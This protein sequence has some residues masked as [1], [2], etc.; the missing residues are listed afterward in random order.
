MTMKVMHL[1]WEFPPYKV[2]GIGSVLDDLTRHQAAQGI[3]TIVVTCGFK[4][5][6]GYEKKDGV[7]IYRFNADYIPAEDF[8]SWALQMGMLMQ[9]KASE[10]INEHKDIDL[11]HAHDWLVATPATSLKHI[12]RIPLVSTIHALECGRYGGIK[13][14][15]QELIH[16]LER[17]LAFESWKII[18]NSGF[19]KDSVCYSLQV[20]LDKICVVPNGV[21]ASRMRPKDSYE[22]GRHMYA[23]P[24]ERIVLYVGRM[25]WEKGVDILVGAIPHV[26]SSNPDAKFVFAGK[27]YMLDRLK[28][29]AHDMGIGDKALFLGYVDDDRLMDLINLSDMMVVPSRY[30]PFGI[31]PLE[32][33]ACGKPV[34][35]TDTGGL[36]ET[37]DHG[38]DGLK[39]WPESSNSIAWGVSKLL[40]DDSLKHTISEKGKKKV[41]E[42]YNWDRISSDV[43][44]VYSTVSNEYSKGEWKPADN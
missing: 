32:A 16:S 37:V 41:L 34:I 11:I 12:Y 44:D 8:H 29:Q 19:M 10:V 27:G 2:G 14:D 39:A 42:R 40:S 7:H 17:K 13:G 6:V 26:L 15:R 21:D 20:P 18:C 25:V 1:S 36:S 3:E 43:S 33:M 30:E 38:N 4:G 24:H 9:N 31:T 5:M 22:D 23:M 35:V 28:K